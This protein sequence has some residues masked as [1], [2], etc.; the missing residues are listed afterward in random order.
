MIEHVEIHH[1]QLRQFIEALSEQERAAPPGSDRYRFDDKC[2][3]CDRTSTLQAD[4][5]LGARIAQACA[6][7]AARC[8]R[9]EHLWQPAPVDEGW[10]VGIYLCY[11]CGAI[12]RKIN[13]E[14]KDRDSPI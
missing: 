12:A 3:A 8:A 5:E 7:S 4:A 6:A 14:W 11:A 13:G 10:D 1:G 2:E 9:E